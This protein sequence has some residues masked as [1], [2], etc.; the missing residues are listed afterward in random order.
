[1]AADPREQAALALAE[2]IV[3]ERGHVSDDDIDV[4]RQAGYTDGEITEIVAN[5]ALNIFTNYFNHVAE[6]EVDFPAAPPLAG[7]RIVV[8]ALPNGN[9]NIFS[10]AAPDN[11]TQEGINDPNVSITST[12]GTTTSQPASWNNIELVAVRPDDAANAPSSRGP[13]TSVCGVR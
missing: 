9:I 13:P 11:N 10:D 2:R 3:T 4:V 5:V 12:V 6:T 1:M 7:D 8:T